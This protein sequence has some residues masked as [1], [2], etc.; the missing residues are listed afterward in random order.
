[1]RTIRLLVTLLLV[2]L[3]TGF[4][5]CDKKLDDL[6]ITPSGG[7][8]SLEDVCSKYG[9]SNYKDIDL[10]NYFIHEDYTIINK[11]QANF[12]GLKNN[13]LWVAT[14]HNTSKERLAEGT[15]SSEFQHLCKV[16]KEFEG[17]KDVTIS[18]ITPM[19]NYVIAPSQFIA[20]L[21]YNFKEDETSLYSTLF[22]H[23]GKS[24][25]IRGIGEIH[26]FEWYKGSVLINNYCY[27][28]DG[29]SI[30]PCFLP[31]G[32]GGLDNIKIYA[33]LSYNEVAYHWF[34]EDGAFV[35]RWDG[36]AKQ[37]IW[38]IEL[39]ELSEL[40]FNDQYKV[41]FKL[42]DSSTNIWKFDVTITSYDGSKKTINYEVNIETGILI[43]KELPITLTNLKG[44]W[45]MTKCY[46]WEYSDKGVKE[47]WTEDVKGEYI[48]FEDED[49]NG[50]YNDGFKTYYFASSINGNKLVL[51]NSDW[52]GGK[53]V[54][55]T[56][57]TNT[58]LHITATDKVSEENYE[59]K[60][61]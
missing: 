58:E 14:Y 19:W 54:T 46:G 38:L 25:E 41:D 32:D 47:D 37:N 2:T 50:G 49:G 28:L 16:F 17:Y 8:G 53:D 30:S 33:P 7:N 59:M 56:K 3:C 21:K 31:H 39:K 12:T 11:Q 22:Y 10:L 34:D 45:D 18:K 57:L 26:I 27:T 42:S 29:D 35:G 36:T 51:R 23:N 40:I 13:H 52:L 6:P 61:R 5:S 43:G 24:K 20:T 1:M 60:R 44:A 48:F 9:I 15:C 4:Y 55:I